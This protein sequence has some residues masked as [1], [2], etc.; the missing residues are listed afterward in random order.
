MQLTDVLVWSMQIVVALGCSMELVVFLRCSIQ[1][2]VIPILVA[3]KNEV[4]IYNL[5]DR[6]ACP[7]Y[8]IDPGGNY[9]SRPVESLALL[10]SIISG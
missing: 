5:G 10:N 6:V 2:A 9:R 1:L 3:N 7:D 8:S 4:T